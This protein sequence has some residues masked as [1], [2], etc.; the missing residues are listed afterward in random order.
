MLTVPATPRFGHL[1]SS[2]CG[3][4]TFPSV[5]QLICHLADRIR[6]VYDTLFHEP[7]NVRTVSLYVA[8]TL[9]ALL[10]LDRP[11]KKG[12][13][14]QSRGISRPGRVFGAEAWMQA[15][16]SLTLAHIYEQVLVGRSPGS[17]VTRS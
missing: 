10:G 1:L 15:K 13:F 16:P 6:G 8:K 11:L 5:K 17:A 14:P 2:W 7:D 9:G 4:H 3:G 12:V